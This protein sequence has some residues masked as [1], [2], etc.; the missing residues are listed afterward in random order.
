MTDTD[1]RARRRAPPRLSR[2]L[3]RFRGIAGWALAAHGIPGQVSASPCPSLPEPPCSRVQG[4]QGGRRLLWG[5]AALPASRASTPQAFH[6]AEATAVPGQ[7]QCLS[8]TKRKGLC[9]AP[10]FERKSFD[11]WAETTPTTI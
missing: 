1:H 11:G 8:S 3:L 10:V 7:H 9:I 4:L 6:A 5:C 2:R